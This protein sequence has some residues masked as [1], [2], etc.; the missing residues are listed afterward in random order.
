MARKFAVFATVCCLSL[1][2]A[3]TADAAS[4]AAAADQALSFEEVLARARASAEELAVMAELA[5]AQREIGATSPR[6][7]SGPVLSAAAG[8][9]RGSGSID[10]DVAVDLDLPLLPRTNG[11]TEAM[12]ALEGAQKVLPQAARLETRSRIVSAWISLWRADQETRLRAQDVATVERWLSLLRRRFEQGAE[13]LFEVD[14]IEL[15]LEQ[16]RATAREVEASKTA[17]LSE[18][19]LWMDP[20]PEEFGDLANSEPPAPFAAVSMALAPSRPA[21]TA[22]SLG[23][24]STAVEARR[25]LKVALAR[26]ERA[27]SQS[28]WALRSGLA[29]EADESVA[30]VGLSYRFPLAKEKAAVAQAFDAEV[31]A[32]EREAR[33]RQAALA[34]R[35]E[36]ARERWLAGMAGTV[37]TVLQTS[38]RPNDSYNE[39]TLAAL[40]LRLA[41][42]KARPSETLLLRRSVLAAEVARLDRR[43]LHLAAAWEIAIL[44]TEELP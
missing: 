1:L 34:A 2:L 43:A 25:D 40:E 5:A 4:D 21:N 20:P 16:A 28:R 14:L 31:A 12:L 18:L 11:R 6:F 9:R 22:I 7:A 19:A 42:G 8:P 44:T 15:E 3:R 39:R 13:A 36:L 24:L 23:L 17:A 35:F 10:P 33:E 41:E 27:R 37:G 38:A 32:L 30:H 29:R 26:F